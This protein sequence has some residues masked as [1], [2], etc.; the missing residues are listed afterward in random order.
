MAD[1]N[2]HQAITVTNIQ[3][4]ILIVLDIEKSQYA[5]WAELFKIH[6]IAYDAIDHIIP[7]SITPSTESSAS[8]TT[9][10]PTPD[11]KWKYLDG[12]VL[13]W[14]YSTIS[15]DL[16]HMILRTN[17]TAAKTWERLQNIFQDNKYTCALYLNRQLNN[18]KFDNFSSASAYCQEIKVLVDQLSNVGDHVSEDRM[19]L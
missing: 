15:N 1:P 8:T 17:T 6:Y 4:I 7:P 9:D 13:Q 10:P 12:I 18:I 14:I 11:P 3:N 19:V 16:L 2:F 5:S